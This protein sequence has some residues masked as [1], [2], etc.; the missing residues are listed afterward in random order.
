MV[1]IL[2]SAYLP[3]GWNFAVHAE[4]SDHTH[5]SAAPTNGLGEHTLHDRPN[6]EGRQGGAVAPAVAAITLRQLQDGDAS[7]V[8]MTDRWLRRE[9]QAR[10]RTA[11]VP[12][13]PARASDSN[14]PNPIFDP[15]DA[16][17]GA[18]L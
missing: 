3:T 1:A 13:L 12:P 7:S 16:Y 14:R 10:L 8:S 2:T 18:V 15:G 5:L 9:R 11:A 6:V 4:Q 17:S